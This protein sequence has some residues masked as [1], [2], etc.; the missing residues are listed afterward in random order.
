[1]KPAPDA[2]PPTFNPQ[3]PFKAIAAMA[4]NRVIGNGAQ[5]PWHLPEDFRWFKETTMG[6][7]L[8]MGRRTF[9]SIGRVLPGRQ[10]LVLTRG[11]F[12]HPEVTVIRSLDDIAAHLDGR[13][14]FIAGGAQVYA[15]ALPRCA[16]LF[17]THVLGEPEGNVFFPPFEHAFEPV[18]VL[19]EEAAFRIV[20]YRNRA[21]C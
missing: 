9:E 8:V 15:A 13:E 3:L 10:T 2:Q 20:H 14:C 4:G 16:D 17:L 6:Q 7:V 1:M 11:E 21:L 19:R 5:I 18:A 12:A